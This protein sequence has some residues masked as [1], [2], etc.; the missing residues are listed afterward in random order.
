MEGKAVKQ[1]MNFS[2]G[3]A[4]VYVMAKSADQW[5]KNSR[6]RGVEFPWMDI[7]DRRPALGV[8]EALNGPAGHGI[9]K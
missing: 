6:L 8:V 7:H 3:R 5:T 1:A 2:F 9:R 4:Q